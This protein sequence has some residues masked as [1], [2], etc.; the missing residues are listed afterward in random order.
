MVVGHPA[1]TSLP[2][3]IL[4]DN[5]MKVIINADVFCRLLWSVVVWSVFVSFMVAVSI[6]RCFIATHFPHQVVAG[7]IVGKYIL[8][9]TG[10]SRHYLR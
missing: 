2:L 10:G 4:N 3:Y 8:P 9:T 7:T 6:S 1:W 5:V